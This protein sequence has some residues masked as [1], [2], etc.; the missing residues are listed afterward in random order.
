MTTSPTSPA[1]S[2]I[3]DAARMLASDRPFDTR[4]LDLL[5]LL[6]HVLGCR[7]ARLAGRA[8]VPLVLTDGWHEPWDDA[9][10]ESVATARAPLRRVVRR[11]AA[12][13]GDDGTM[14]YLGA[15]LA[16]DGRLWGVIELRASGDEGLDL[17]EQ[18]V[19]AGLVPLLAVAVAGEDGVPAALVTRVV[20]ASAALAVQA[21]LAPAN[22]ARL[23][24]RQSSWL[25]ETSAALDREVTLGALLG[26]LLAR[27][28]EATGAEAGVINLVDHE[29][30]E[31]VVQVFNGYG[32]DPL[33]RDQYGEPRRRWPL[34]AGL[35]GRAARSGRPLLLR[36]MG[37]DADVQLF[38]P[39]IRAE[40]AAPVVLNGTTLA[41]LVLDSPRA[42]AFG[43]REAAV[44]EAL[45]TIIAPA[46]RRALD[47]QTLLDDGAQL[48]QVFGG[49]PLGLALTDMQGRLLRCNPAWPT[50]W[51]VSPVDPTETVH[52][53]IDLVRQLLPRLTDPMGFGDFCTGAESAPADIQDITVRLRNPHRELHLL[54]VPTRDTLGELTGRVWMVSD[55]TRERE[56]D[57]LK[58]EFISIVSHELK[59]P[60][61]SILGYTELM[62]ARDFTPREQREF[63]Q[64]VFNEATQLS[65]MVEDLLGV[66]KLESGTL[67]LNQWIVSL[68]QLFAEVATQMSIFTA[69]HP[70]VIDVPP[71]LPPAYVDR[72]K[73]RQV[74]FNLLSN[75]V[76][77]SPRGG[78]IVLGASVA[79]TLPPEH[80]PGEYLV[81]S[82]KDH[83]LGIEPEHLPKIWDR[84]YRVDNSNTRRIGGTGLGL[85]IVRGLVEL[86]NGRIWADSSVGVGSTFRFSVPQATETLIVPVSDFSHLP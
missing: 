1:L 9:L 14:T 71:Q 31:L 80:P 6:R 41:V 36:D 81:I 69:R 79:T 57:R 42:A 33:P 48:S 2:L 67:M 37:A 66:S 28:M 18:T 46:L 73:I 7:D 61:T 20:P 50:I 12:L 64:T 84:F 72:D 16:W 34:D 76:K 24:E 60:L 55:V 78:Q 22:H 62:L 29:R 59:T 11:R 47:R 56:A 23:T 82:V 15:P 26:T 25:S 40:L 83:G 38:N 75:A 21:P 49:I 70:L 4:V 13:P 5:T 17:I 44:V 43:P 65:K 86:H 39:A 77:Y 8:V 32:R 10:T 52:L 45:C 19:V 53:Q 30:D 51:G 63:V 54:L 35:A 3:T 85:S 58:S 74:L 27:A 68:R